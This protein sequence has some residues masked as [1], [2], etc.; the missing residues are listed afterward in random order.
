MHVQEQEVRKNYIGS[1][2]DRT[3]DQRAIAS[4]SHST[5]LMRDYVHGLMA[6]LFNRRNRTAWAFRAPPPAPAEMQNEI[7]ELP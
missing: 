7:S 5:P 6:A 4:V 1:V 2:C 3:E